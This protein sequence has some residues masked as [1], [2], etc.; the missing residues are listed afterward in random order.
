MIYKDFLNRVD[1]GK[2]GYFR[3]IPMGLP[4]LSSCLNGIQKGTYTVLFAA[5]GRKRK[6]A[7]STVILYQ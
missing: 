6:V 1:K 7:D 4:A 5:E 3:G 2:K